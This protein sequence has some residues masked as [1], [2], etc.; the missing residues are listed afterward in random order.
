MEAV[1]TENKILPFDE[2]KK[3]YPNEWVLIGNP[4]LDDTPI[5]KAVVHKLQG[6][7]VLYHSIDKREIGYNA[8]TVKAGYDTFVCVFTGETP[9]NRRFWLSNW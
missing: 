2:I 5:L 8:K 1:I 9:Q 7:V 4:I 6:G 3:L